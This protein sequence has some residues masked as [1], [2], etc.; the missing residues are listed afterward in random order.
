MSITATFTPLAERALVVVAAP[1]RRTPGGGVGSVEARSATA[2]TLRSGVTE[3]TSGS[4][5]SWSACR[6]ESSAEKPFRA[7]R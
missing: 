2:R 1:I 4:A 6:G 7:R 5:S 3:A